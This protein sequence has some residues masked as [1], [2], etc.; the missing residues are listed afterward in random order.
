MNHST[1][2][3]RPPRTSLPRA[4]SF[5]TAGER[6]TTEALLLRK[7]A[8]GEADAIVALF[9]E[10]RGLVSAIARGARKSTKRFGA[11]EPLHLLRVTFE[12]KGGAELCTL[13]EATLAAPR[14]GLLSSLE[15]MEIASAAL[16]WVRRATPP[17]VAEPALWAD[18]NALLDSL[19]GLPESTTA[20]A[21]L[22]TVGLRLLQGAGWGLELSACVR[23]G[24]ECGPDATACADGAQGGLVCRAC[25]GARWLLRPARR[26][27]LQA[28]MEGDCTLLTNDDAVCAIELVTATLEAHAAH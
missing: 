13:V 22:A 8:Y 18:M 23:C 4:A 10:T 6:I 15:H 26:R 14:L 9:T 11:L 24:R 27:A 16:Q 7:V 1:E 19:D 20:R 5:R 3:R 17:Q 2:K 21:N 25:G 28:A 12:E